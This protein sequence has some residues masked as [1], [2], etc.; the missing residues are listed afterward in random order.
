MDHKHN[1]VYLIVI[2]KGNHKP[3]ILGPTTGEGILNMAC[4]QY[5]SKIGL[6]VYGRAFQNC[7]PLLNQDTCNI[8][9]DWICSF[10]EFPA[11]LPV[12]KPQ[13]IYKHLQ[14]M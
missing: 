13:Q 5:K 4:T 3:V 1:L 11:W 10:F 14:S 2:E 7:L 6:G 9:L 12:I 8:I